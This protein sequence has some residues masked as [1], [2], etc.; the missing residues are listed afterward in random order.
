MVL[1]VYCFLKS[2][3]SFREYVGE[4]N[5]E[6]RWGGKN[7]YANVPLVARDVPGV[8]DE[9]DD[10]EGE[11]QHGGGFDQEGEHLRFARRVRREGRGDGKRSG[12]DGASSA[13]EVQD[14]EGVA[15]LAFVLIT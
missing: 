7:D 5:K 13:Q 11:G 3:C 8:S 6:S 2:Q 4:D 1:T 15:Y 14:L 10:Q 9:G 12:A